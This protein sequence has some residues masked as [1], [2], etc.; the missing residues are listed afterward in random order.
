ME[1]L[2]VGVGV[3][4]LL[5]LMAGLKVD[6]FISLILVSLVVGA[7]EGMPWG[8]I[9]ASI[10]KGI[11][12]Q[13]NSLILILAFGAMLGK[14][15][16]DSGAAQR[17]A[18]TFINTFG[19]KNAQWAMLVTAIVV[20][21]TMFFEAGFIVLIPIVFTI[22]AETGMPLMYVGL[23]AVIGLSTT[24]SFLPPHPGPAAVSTLFGANMGQT[25]LLGLII[26]IPAAV[27]VGIF[28]SRTKWVLSAEA[29][30]PEGLVTTKVF[31]EEEMPG[32]GISIFSAL[33]PIILMAVSTFGDLLL[34]KKDP[35]LTY[36]HFFGDAPVALL[37]SVLISMY[38]L[39]LNRGKTMKE[40]TSSVG[41]SV[42]AIAMIILV[43]AAG[44]AFKQVIVDAGVGKAITAMTK[45]MT[46]SPIILAWIIAASLRIAVGSATVAIITA[47]GIVLPMV[48]TS[49]ISPE[50]MVLATSCGSIF[51]SHVNDPGFW[52][53]KEYF[54]LPVA[55]AIKVRTT[56]T[57]IL[58]VLGLIGVLGLHL[59]I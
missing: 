37:I 21:I 29:S 30:I 8:T 49:G 12:S 14:L 23:P 48:Q 20:G 11:G 51:A 45:G 53:F 42:K 35:L 28:Y 15:L 44:G 16:A 3:I 59:F 52:M 40:V 38:T 58:S 5:V 32:F 4:L 34:A 2:W 6:A 27:I 24:H 56:Y 41:V 7:L 1:L 25:L 47:G 19:K 57:C 33:I 55:H 46:I 39:G 26:A 9:T 54:N 31:K 36:L 22:V 18:T 10:Y 50:L 13:L 43:I 17:I